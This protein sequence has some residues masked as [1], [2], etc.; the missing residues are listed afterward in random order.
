VPIVL[1]RGGVESIIE[2]DLTEDERE[3]FA[4][5]VASI[6]EAVKRTSSNL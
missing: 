1:G 6:V 5:S 4:K 2:L 3:L